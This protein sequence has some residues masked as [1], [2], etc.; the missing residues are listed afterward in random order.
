MKLKRYTY[1]IA[2]GAL[3]SLGVACDSDDNDSMMMEDD[4]TGMED[5]GMME[6]VDF[7]GTFMQVDYMGRPGINTVLSGTG[8]IKNMH[9]T[10]IPS[11]MAATFQPGFESQLE[12]YHDGYAVALGLTPEDVDYE[13]NIL[14]D[15]LNGPEADGYTD[16]P[17]SATVLTSVLAADVL[18]VAPNLPTTYFNPGAGAPAYEGAIGLTGRTLSDDVIDVS[19]ILLFGGGN[20][21]RFAGQDGLPLLVSDGVGFSANI[22]TEFPYLGAP[23]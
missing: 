15:I 6:E 3:L 11:E 4:M 23:E 14:G 16:N 20:G 10:A 21:A 12:A 18:E 13:P 8:E 2:L 17:V 1:T 5:D 22:S 7:S 19:L 9:N